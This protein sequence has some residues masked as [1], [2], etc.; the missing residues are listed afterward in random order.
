LTALPL[1]ATAPAAFVSQYP[2][3]S[4]VAAIP[5]TGAAR[6]PVVVGPDVDAAAGDIDANIAAA[7]RHAAIILVVDRFI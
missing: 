2:E 3:P 6:V 4:G 5:T 7:V 1:A